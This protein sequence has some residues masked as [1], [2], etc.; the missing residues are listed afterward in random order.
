MLFKDKKIAIIGGGLVGSL[1][2][3]YLANK[4]AKVC[5]YERRNDMREQDINAGRSINLA[6]SNRGIKSLKE[7]GIDNEVLANTMPMFR[8]IMHSTEGDLTNQ[9]YGKKGQAIFSVGRSDLNCVLMDLAEK[10]GVKIFFSQKCLDIDFES[11]T[12]YFENK[13]SLK[14]DFVFGADGTGSVVRKKM[15]EKYSV[16]TEERFIDCGYKELT[17]PA[18]KNGEY[19]ISKDALHIWPRGSYMIIALPNPDATFTCTLFFPMKGHNSFENLKTKKDVLDFFKI[20]F[21]DLLKLIPDLSEQYFYNPLSPLGLVRSESWLENNIALIGDSCHATVPF[22]GQGMNCGFEDCYLLNEYINS[23]KSFEEFKFNLNSFLKERKK[24]TDAMQELSLYNFIVM[25]DKTA[26]K[27][28]LLQKKIEAKFSL[29]HPDK[30]IP[31]YSMVSFSDIRYS[32]ALEIGQKQNLIMEK[33]MKTPNINTIWESKE[34]ERLI[35]SY[36]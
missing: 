4:G 16:K 22:Y 17:I 23:C 30:W 31:L 3:I 35:L 1:L 26:D 14:Y 7:V 34:I 9:E 11:T 28:F 19:L 6:L 18:G 10:K 15:K 36:L 32:D 2:S 25:R 12:L 8:R 24:D 20:N 5:I 13:N 27:D 21:N 33:V 29:K